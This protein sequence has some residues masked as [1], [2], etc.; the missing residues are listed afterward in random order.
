ML[1]T[2]AALKEEPSYNSNP[3]LGL[4]FLL[5]HWLSLRECVCVCVW[6]GGMLKLG[7]Q[8]QGGGRILDID[9]QGG[10]GGS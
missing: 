6:E 3:C 1:K 9:G 5:I 10:G 8:V 2:K 7:V 4:C